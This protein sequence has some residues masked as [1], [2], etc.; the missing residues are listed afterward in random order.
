MEIVFH[1][2]T[3]KQI[4]AFRRHLPHG[5]LIHGQKGSGL[6]TTARHLAGKDLAGIIEPADSKGAIQPKTG[7]ISV[8]AIRNLYEQTRAKSNSRNVFIIDN[9]ER[10]SRGAQAAFLKLLEEPA[11]HVHFILTSH[12]PQMLLPTIRSRVQSTAMRRLTTAQTAAF[13]DELSITDTQTKRQLE[14]LA[15]GLPAELTRLTNDDDYFKQQASIMGSV[16][17]FLT[18]SLFEKLVLIHQVYQDKAKTLQ[19]LEGALTVTER[20]L[21]ASPQQNLVY[22][23][24]MLMKA[25]ERIEANCNTRLQLMAFVVQ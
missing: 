15:H 6:T 25:K 13:L 20:S 19:L 21:H 5:V 3:Q 14:Y 9:A 23:L 1:P 22:Q 4:E 7:T 11:P 24:D 2:E 18:G 12:T 8:E 10:M 17:T 16:R